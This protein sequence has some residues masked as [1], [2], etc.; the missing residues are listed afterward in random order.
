M[1]CF[2]QVFSCHFVFKIFV[3]YLFHRPPPAA[4]D[5]A[6]QAT[7]TAAPAAD[8]AHAAAADQAL[9]GAA[10]AADQAPTQVAMQVDDSPGPVTRSRSVASPVHA[11]PFKANKR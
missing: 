7:S 6:D 11:S 2:D 3:Q 8:Q 5:R 1:S 4:A 9:A 10:A